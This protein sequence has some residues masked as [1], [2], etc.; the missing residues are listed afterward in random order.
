MVKVLDLRSADLRARV[1]KTL[2]KMLVPAAGSSR[3][4]SVTD[5]AV[6]EYMDN[7]RDVLDIVDKLMEQPDK[8]NQTKRFVER[9]LASL[10]SRGGKPSDSDPWPPQYGVWEKIPTIWMWAWVSGKYPEFTPAIIEALQKSEKGVMSALRETATGLKDNHPVDPRLRDKQI[11][12]RFLDH[13][14]EK[15]GHRLLGWVTRCFSDLKTVNWDGC[16]CWKPSSTVGGQ[17]KQ[18]VW[19]YDGQ[20]VRS[21]C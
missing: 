16:S 1:Q 15:R 17:V 18:Y 13:L 7:A 6:M 14:A 4:S 10:S 20:E 21:Q 11:M 19:A 2:Q 3:A 5:V 12:A 8:I 9:D